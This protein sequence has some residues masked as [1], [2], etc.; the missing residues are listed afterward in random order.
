MPASVRW[1]DWAVFEPA[2]RDAVLAFIKVHNRIP[3]Y[4]ELGA[5]GHR[6]M[7]VAAAT[8]HGGY[9]TVLARLGFPKPTKKP[10][11]SR[12]RDW[13]TFAH[14][15]RPIIAEFLDKHQRLPTSI[16]LKETPGSWIP[17]A[18]FAY[19]GGLPIVYQKLGFRLRLPKALANWEYF[20]AYTRP[21]IAGF[22]KQL[23]HTPVAQHLEDA[24]HNDILQ[25]AYEFHGGYR[26][27][28]KRLGFAK[29][30]HKNTGTGL[31]NWENLETRLRPIIS[32]FI[33]EHGRT[34]Y[35]P[36]LRQQGHF[37]Y[38]CACRNHHGGY[39]AC[40]I[41]MGFPLDKRQIKGTRHN[42]RD[43]VVRR[44]A[45]EQAFPFELKLGLMPST[46]QVQKK[47]PGLYSWWSRKRQTWA[48]YAAELGLVPRHRAVGYLIYFRHVEEALQF[49]EQHGRWPKRRESSWSLD[50]KRRSRPWIEYLKRTDLPKP[51]L[52]AIIE[53]W[54]SH[55]RYLEHHH[56]TLVPSRLHL[57]NHLVIARNES[58]TPAS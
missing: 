36:E 32:K 40:L 55:I 21:V 19:H 27:I 17:A 44:R 43:P 13:D 47:F 31:A 35:V 16:D 12:R 10:R 38:I 20:A 15:A 18:A 25:A 24:G 23:G 49:F 33:A 46:V 42:W 5:F 41:R 29:P 39:V 22:T 37:R 7:P 52:S 26:A 3:T 50:G 14:D 28:L 53:R 8:F 2:A 45:L 9:R 58:M 54:R 51:V 11:R 34:P 6:W 1:K 48:A 30:R 4:P 57:M 56:P